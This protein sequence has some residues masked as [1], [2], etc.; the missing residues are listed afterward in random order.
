MKLGTTDGPVQ[1]LRE[2]FGVLA[3][4][5]AATEVLL[6]HQTVVDATFLNDYPALRGIIRLGVGYD[7]VDLSA[8]QT[9][10][11]DVANI[12][13]YCTEEVALSA[14]AFALDWARGH[15]ELEAALQLNPQPW[16]ALSLARVKGVSQ[17][18]FGAIGVGRI[19]GRVLALAEGLGFRV[20]GY[21]TDPARCTGVDSL[22]ALLAAA[23]IVSLHVPLME[24]T[25]GM[26][27]ARFFQRMRSGSL[28]INTARG[29][30]LGDSHA[31]IAALETGRLSG[32]ALDVL[33]EEPNVQH[34][35]VFRHWQMNASAGRLR[36]TP[37]N[38]FHSQAS[39]QRL[40][41]FAGAEVEHLRAHG[42]FKNSLCTS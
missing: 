2:R 8:C 11:I 18:T 14:V 42:R 39:A 33:P 28:L 36:I 29:G 10:N 12:P 27:D 7:K 41:E 19:G 31:L 16:Q 17:L 9:R 13:D 30:L 26:L 5:P 34:S 32:A 23:D 15:A 35:R 25:R 4:S 21:D 3:E 37:H 1:W 6:V 38:A 40:L 24:G 20:V 22:E